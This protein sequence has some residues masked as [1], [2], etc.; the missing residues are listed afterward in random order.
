[1]QTRQNIVT[2]YPM[3][4]SAPVAPPSVSTTF[5][6]GGAPKEAQNI[7]HESRE[8]M[9]AEGKAPKEAHNYAVRMMQHAGWYKG[10]GNK[11][12][13][14]TPD[15][16]K[17][18]NV[19][20]AVKQPDGRFVI[21]DV[22]VF[23]PN[24]VKLDPNE[25]PIMF[26]PAQIGQMIDNTN[27]A[28]EAGG[29]KPGLV[30]GHPHQDQKAL[31]IQQDVLGHPVHWRPSE[32]GEGW[33]KVDLID[34][35]PETV[36]RMKD[37]RL[38]GLSAA[39]N[40]DAKGLN[41]RFG[42][43]ALLGGDTQSLSHLPLTEIF[44]APSQ[45]CFSAESEPFTHNLKGSRM[46]NPKF[47]AAAKDCYG[48]MAAAYAAMEAGEPTA[49]EKISEAHKKHDEFSST[50]AADLQINNKEAEDGPLG[51]EE[52]AEMTGG[53][54]VGMAPEMAPAPMAPPQAVAPQYSA[55]EEVSF[56][57]DPEAAFSAL[58][59][60]VGSLTQTLAEK[61]KLNRQLL[62]TVNML[63][64]KGLRTE[65]AAELDGLKRAGHV[66][67]GAAE[68]EG[69]F[70]D[71]LASPKQA[72][73]LGRLKKLLRSM[74]KGAATAGS[75]PQAFSAEEASQPFGA[76]SDDEIKASLKRVTDKLSFSD[77]EYATTA[78]TD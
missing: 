53:S 1:M 25:D 44:S 74:P 7:Y 54:P 64:H 33:V 62:S 6:A 58:Q 31:G 27:A 17:K 71:A 76:A 56:S 50:Y 40:R 68:I 45:L 32:R 9:L 34:V 22:D 69:M 73:S 43:V 66:L 30:I 46:K 78:M 49:M 29:Q 65:F 38:T 47:A 21:E 4:G 36:V 26:N 75:I 42:H 23:Y 8:K 35:T 39:I 5:S 20:E 2:G 61:D 11:W 63:H 14:L 18:I 16:R 57:A 70:S 51:F 10:S 37:R 41:R 19:R 13:R 52:P 60:K 55:G 3:A 28:I 48:T 59:T 24:A 77:D 72:E 67:P 12:K 15:L